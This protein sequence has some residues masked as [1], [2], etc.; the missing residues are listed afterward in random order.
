MRYIEFKSGF[1]V[2]AIVIAIVGGFMLGAHIA[3]QM[4]FG[5][6]LPRALDI[7]I[8]VHGHLQLVGW[9]GLF[10]MGVSLY[11]LPRFT[12]VPFK[13]RF[14]INLIFYLTVF[15]LITGSF[16]RFWRPYVGET[17]SNVFEILSKIGLVFEFAGILFYLILVLSLISDV[18]DFKRKGMSLV[19]PFFVSMLNGWLVYA[20]VQV[21]IVFVGEDLWKSLN[22]WGIDVFMRLVLFPVAFAF[23]ILTFPLYIHLPPVKSG[24]KFVGYIYF[25]FSLIYAFFDLPF[26]EVSDAVRNVLNVLVDVVVFVLLFYSGIFQRIF[27][28]WFS[29]KKSPFWRRDGS[30]GGR[31]RRGYA[32]YGEFGRFELL[33]YS[34]YF[35]LIVS[36]VLDLGMAIYTLTGNT[37]SYGSDPVRHTFLLGFITILILGMAQR[38]LPGFMHRKRIASKTIVML[39]FVF[40]NLAVVLRVFPFVLSSYFPN[41]AGLFLYGFGVSG[42]FAIAAI[43]LLGVNLLKTFKDVSAQV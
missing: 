33:I 22:Q 35:W 7:W 20:F 34:A 1:I 10:I 9:V 39:T 31:A 8:S 43:V 5:M 30:G 42:V 29:L 24:V 28:P 38:M 14:K 37:P 21:S 41:F 32:D 25:V 40:G 36:V 27:L 3:M 13:D 18:P 4:A 12:G 23:S 15:G 26:I 11:F 19:R 17:L 2:S 6:G 16:F